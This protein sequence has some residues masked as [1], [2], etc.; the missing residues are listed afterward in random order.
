MQIVL[1]EVDQAAGPGLFVSDLVLG[2]QN[3]SVGNVDVGFQLGEHHLKGLFHVFQDNV[4][5]G[6]DLI[7]RLLPAGARRV[8]RQESQGVPWPQP[9]GCVIV[10]DSVFAQYAAHHDVTYL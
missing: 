5:A 6:M 10:G 9:L 2:I 8:H 3:G 4:Y 1:L 7:Q